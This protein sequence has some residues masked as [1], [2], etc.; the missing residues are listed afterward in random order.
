[1][2]WRIMVKICKSFDVCLVGCVDVICPPQVNLKF[3]YLFIFTYS[4]KFLKLIGKC[5]MELIRINR[6][7]SVMFDFIA[8]FIQHHCCVQ[9]CYC[10]NKMSCCQK[11]HIVS[12]CDI[13]FHQRPFFPFPSSAFHSQLSYYC[14]HFVG[15]GLKVNESCSARSCFTKFMIS[16]SLIIIFVDHDNIL[17]D[18]S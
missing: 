1:M 4:V 6:S 14:M 2:H 3:T 10:W 13:E 8:R 9:E 15:E 16:S 5:T 11:F 18:L 12:N 17:S 7:N